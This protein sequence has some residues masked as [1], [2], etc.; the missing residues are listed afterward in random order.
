MLK[1]IRGLLIGGRNIC[2]LGRGAFWLCF[3]IALY[4]WAIGE[5]I[6]AGHFGVLTAIMG[7]IFGSKYIS[8]IKKKQPIDSEDIN[9]P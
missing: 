4:R 8:K 5:D 9:Y 6:H 1:S 7:Y 3:F 2:S